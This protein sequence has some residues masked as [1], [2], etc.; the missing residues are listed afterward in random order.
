MKK[1]IAI[2]MALVLCIGCLGAAAADESAKERIPMLGIT[3]TYPRAMV[4]A[5]G[6]I[7]M[8]EAVKLGDGVYYDY[9]YY[10]TVTRDE[11]AKAFEGDEQAVLAVQESTS[12][13]RCISLIPK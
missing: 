5:K 1:L 7:G 2:F 9:C 13:C 8:D 11:W 6:L 12:P 3:F 4:E 10:S